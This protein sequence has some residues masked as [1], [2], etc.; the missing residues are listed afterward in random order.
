MVINATDM[1]SPYLLLNKS[2][3]TSTCK[4]IKNYESNIANK[5]LIM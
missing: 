2:E 4:L 3:M 1:T 5:L